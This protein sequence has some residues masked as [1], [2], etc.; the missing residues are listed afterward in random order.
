MF[1]FLVVSCTFSQT[2]DT[3]YPFKI[4]IK[5]VGKPLILISGLACSGDVWKQ[6][7]DSLQKNYECHILTLAGSSKQEAIP[8]DNGYLP[9]LKKGVLRY[10]N[11]RIK[12]KPIIIGH[13]LGGFLALLIA[14][15]SSNMLDKIVIVDSYPFLPT[16]FN[17][18]ATEENI[19]PQAK[20][21][22]NMLL[23]M[24][25][26]LFEHQ[27]EMNLTAMI[28]DSKNIQMAKKWAMDSD[29]ET[30]AQATFELLTTDLR[31]DLQSI[32]I[33]M[34]VLGSWYGAKDY[35]I[36]QEMVKT[37]FETQFSKV[38]NHKIVIADKAKHFIM[39]DNPKWLYREVQLFT[40]YDEQ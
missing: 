26:S 38:Q 35:G 25:D 36:T 31:D 11:E 24:T 10:I 32:K 6:T 19:L 3:K 8:L 2:L 4:D 27:Q 20:A 30:V 5:G 14:S 39:L 33:P 1:V 9:S 13:S 18:N 29:R 21:M 16:T 23:T 12:D 40:A 15:D 7:A 22:R 34:L 37:N 28:T 17:P